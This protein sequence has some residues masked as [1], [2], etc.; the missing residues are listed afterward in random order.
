ML[1]K[2]KVLLVNPALIV[3]QAPPVGVFWLNYKQAK[4]FSKT[5]PRVNGKSI[6]YEKGKDFKILLTVSQEGGT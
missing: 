6:Q 4:I 2:I 1:S 5:C 3:P